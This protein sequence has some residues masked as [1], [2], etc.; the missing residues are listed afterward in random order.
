MAVSYVG[1]R[2]NLLWEGADVNDWNHDTS[3]TALW[4]AERERMMNAAKNRRRYYRLGFEYS[5][6]FRITFNF[7]R[8]SWT[9]SK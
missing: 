2:T 4:L 8:W 3:S 1:Q 6:P 7:W 9:W 5:A